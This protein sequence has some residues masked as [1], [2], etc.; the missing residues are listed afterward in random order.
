MK[1][2]YYPIA[3]NIK[4]RPALIAGGGKVAERKV[5]VL[6]SSGTRV[7]VISPD[8]TPALKQLAESGKIRWIDRGVRRSDIRRI[9]IVIA[10]TSNNKV[11]RQI[12]R[13]A[14]FQKT[15]IN[16]VDNP[17]LSNFISPALLRKN[18]VIIAVYTDGKDP[19][20]SRDLKNFLKEH[21]DVFLSYR[22][23]L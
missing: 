2:D 8:L 12:S 13:W 20:L 23:R 15:L 9:D 16:V 6:L 21:W 10:A 3:L 14:K 17:G 7:K 11:N 1:I 5:A 19:V 22:R 4:S 18:G